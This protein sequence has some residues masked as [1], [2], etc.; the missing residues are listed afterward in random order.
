MARRRRGRQSERCRRQAG[1]RQ[2]SSRADR[3]V[4]ARR[5]APLPG[6]ERMGTSDQ[7]GPTQGQAPPP[8]AG[9]RAASWP[10][11][12]SGCAAERSWSGEEDSGRADPDGVEVDVATESERE[13]GAK[14]VV[15]GGARRRAD[16][17]CAEAGAASVGGRE[18]GVVAT[19]EGTRR[20]ANRVCSVKKGREGGTT[21]VFD[22]DM[23]RRAERS[24]AEAPPGQR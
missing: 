16:R 1:H 3:I 11:W 15:N 9:A 22:G 8:G 13:G 4:P 14:A 19:V 24:G 21:A 23:R 10:S 6:A 20:R 12:G 18:D 2:R 7:V 17:S 5:L